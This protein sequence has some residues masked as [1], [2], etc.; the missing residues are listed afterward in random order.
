MY[1]LLRGNS[2]TLGYQQDYTVSV[3]T[4]LLSILVISKRSRRLGVSTA[5]T[6]EDTSQS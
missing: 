6:L 1:R 2:E 3:L 4:D 5:P